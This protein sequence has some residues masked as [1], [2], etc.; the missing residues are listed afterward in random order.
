MDSAGKDR[1]PAY[2]PTLRRITLAGQWLLTLTV[3]LFATMGVMWPEPYAKVWQLI[4]AHIVGGRPANVLIGINLGFSLPFIYLQCILEDLIIL[5]LF[6]PLLVFGYRHAIEWRV[7]GPAL[8][9]IRQTAHRHKSKVEPY[10]VA[11]LMLFVIFPF[12][13]TGALAAAFVGYLIGMRTSVTFVSVMVGNAIAVALWVWFFNELNQFSGQLAQVLLVIIFGTV[14]SAALITQLRNL[15]RTRRE[16]SES[17]A[18]ENTED[19][20]PH[21]D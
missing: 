16:H 3:V 15:T 8:V 7:L 11:G 13:S 20:A 17:T 21:R 18:P 14:I 12:W 19:D 2:D 9:T 1:V 6:Y 5:F 10:G 4:L